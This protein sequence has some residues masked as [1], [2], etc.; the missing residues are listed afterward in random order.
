MNTLL[1]INNYYYVRGGAEAVFLDHNDIFEAAGWRVVPFSMSH[2]RN[3]QTEWNAYFADEIELG[4]NYGALEKIAKSLRAIYSR[5]AARKVDQ[6][7]TAIRPTVAHAHNVY[8]HLSPSIFARLKKRGIPIVVTLHDLKLACPSYRMISRNQICEKCKTSRYWQAAVNRC[9]HGSIPLSLWVTAESYTHRLLGSYS[10]NVD[11]FVVPSRFYIDKFC[12]WGW[13]RERF[14][15]IPNFVDAEDIAP[16]FAAGKDFVYFGRL[17]HE[18]GVA[19][20]IKAAAAARVAI[21]IVGTGP[22]GASLQELAE[23][24]GVDV[25]FSGYLSGKDLFDALRSAR[26]IVLPSEWYENAPI[27]VLEAYAAGKP[28]IGADIGGIPELVTSGRGATFEPFSVES[29][30]EKL[31]E[32]SSRSDSGIEAMGR[33]ARSYVLTEHSRQTYRERISRVY[34]LLVDGEK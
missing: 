24:L 11:K 31:T 12:E 34:D 7:V 20:L 32:F 14:I 6:L 8:H 19:T 4:E 25:E 33:E 21:R 1:S 17:S 22:E 28:V 5:E 29:L 3:R 13:E 9:M 10:K 27:S 16:G 23:E 18:K 30:A 2:P 26:A 15:Y